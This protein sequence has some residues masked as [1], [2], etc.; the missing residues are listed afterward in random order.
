MGD[1]YIP[2][3]M[4]SYF[5]CHSNFTASLYMTW[6]RDEE[7]QRYERLLWRRRNPLCFHHLLY[8]LPTSQTHHRSRPSINQNLWPSLPS[9]LVNNK[10]YL[11]FPSFNLSFLLFF[12]LSHLSSFP[13]VK[14]WIFLLFFCWVCER[15]DSFCWVCKNIGFFLL[16]LS[17]VSC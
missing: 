14:D 12:N 1:K 9:A 11:I 15:L 17:K 2:A 10:T 7:Q 5:S 8:L 16:G 3:F 13:I 4:R 6:K